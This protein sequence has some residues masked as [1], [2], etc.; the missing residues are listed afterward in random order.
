MMSPT[1]A[2]TVALSAIVV[3]GAIAAWLLN[4]PPWVIGVFLLGGV[5]VIR[6]ILR[7]VK[8]GRARQEP[9]SAEKSSG[10]TF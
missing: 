1:G 2:L 4:I 3:L 8:S 5:A 9:E 6:R 7:R 10:I